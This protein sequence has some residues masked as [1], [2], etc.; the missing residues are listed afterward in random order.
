M[1]GVWGIIGYSFRPMH[2]IKIDNTQALIYFSF[3]NQKESIMQKIALGLI[4]FGLVMAFVKYLDHRGD[5]EVIAHQTEM[6]ARPVLQEAVDRETEMVK[7]SADNVVSS[8]KGRLPLPFP[9]EHIPFE[10]SLMVKVERDNPLQVSFTIQI[11]QRYNEVSSSEILEKSV[12]A[13]SSSHCGDTKVLRLINAG[14]VSR[15][16]IVRDNGT[17]IGTHMI[18]KDSCSR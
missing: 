15:F 1:T 3:L 13:L 7:R 4:V 14:M 2:H 17:P 10:D 12:R 16:I 18:N 8:A 6:V 5:Q 11:N 9:K